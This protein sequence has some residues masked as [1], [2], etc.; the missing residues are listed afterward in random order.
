MAHV[1]LGLLLIAPQSLYDLIKAFEAG[2]AL[3]YSASSGSIKRALDSLLER[4]LIEVA[5]VEPVGRG[6]KV[7]RVTEAGRREFHTWMTSELSGSDLEGAA[8]SRLYFLGLL[9]QP[10]RAPVLHR[11]ETRIVA[12]LAKLS[13][14]DER[15][16]AADVPEELR[17]VATYQ[18][19]TLDYGLASLRFMLGRFRDH[20]DRDEAQRRS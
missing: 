16:N 13:E 11:I 6:R 1:I 12:D 9:D 8:L 14:L 7:Y 5:S 17:E 4:G 3:L 18:R 15:V 10:E 19:A 2:V 20:I